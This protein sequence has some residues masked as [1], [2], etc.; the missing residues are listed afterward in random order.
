MFAFC[1]FIEFVRMSNS[2]ILL[3]FGHISVTLHELTSLR[4]GGLA[5][6]IFLH[7]FLFTSI[8]LSL[9]KTEANSANIILFL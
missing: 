9:C 1:I 2:G 5:I 3:L 4:K 7:H 8:I 6:S